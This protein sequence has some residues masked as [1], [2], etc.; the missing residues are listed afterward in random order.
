MPGNRE[1]IVT[2]GNS[3]FSTLITG[4]IDQIVG[5]PLRELVRLEK[6]EI[7]ALIGR[8]LDSTETN[9]HLVADIPQPAGRSLPIRRRVRFLSFSSPVERAAAHLSF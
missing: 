2:K 3:A 9:V 1:G 6:G 4:Q 8:V 5:A 7:D